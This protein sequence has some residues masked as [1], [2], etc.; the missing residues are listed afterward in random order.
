M[1]IMTISNASFISLN[2][3]T[4]VPSTNPTPTHCLLPK[5][6]YD[7]LYAFYI[8]T[9]GTGWSSECNNWEFSLTNPDYS[10]PCNSWIGVTC[11]NQCHVWLLKLPHCQLRGIIPTQIGNMINIIDLQLY[12]NS[13]TGTIPS[14]IGNLTNRSSSF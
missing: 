5:Q 6:E 14:Q 2:V 1:F 9:N 7:A 8:S 11:D 3:S 10:A 12:N 13:L 4:M